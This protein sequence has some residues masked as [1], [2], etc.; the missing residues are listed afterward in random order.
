MAEKSKVLIVDDQPANVILLQRKLER[1]NLDVMVA[2]NGRQCLQLCEATLPDLI[3]LDVMMPE[4]DGI[5]TCQKLKANP[6]TETIP[7][8]FI[9]AKNT[10]EGKIEGLDVGAVD[11]ITKPIDLDETLAR[12][13]TQ[14]RVRE[15]FRQNLLLQQ[16][17]SEAKQ[18]AVIGAITEGIAHNLN[19]LMGVVVGYLDLLKTD[20]GMSENSRRRLDLIQ[21][22]VQ[23]IIRI[24]KTLTTLSIDES[25]P[26]SEAPI[27]PTL[28]TAI[29]RFKSENG[30]DIPISLHD[31][32]NGENFSTNQEVLES[33]LSRVLM[34][35]Y[36]SYPDGS[37]NRPIDVRDYIEGDQLV[38]EVADQGTGLSEGIRENLFNPFVSSKPDV[39]RGLGLT[40]VQH[41]M[42]CMSGSVEIHNREDQN[43][44]VATLRFPLRSH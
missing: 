43:G 23:R 29:G 33:V 5:E 22:P 12:V 26:L 20:T 36:E 27:H 8:I 3:L 13:R 16:K 6:R 15:L 44:A 14:L 18:A 31:Q 21:A 4:M 34:N 28:A 35:A 2:F 24:V 9:T 39:G 17:L 30:L 38:I 11:Y 1:E 40:L 37:E 32:T 7:V 41:L 25:V 19:N 10:K 42:R